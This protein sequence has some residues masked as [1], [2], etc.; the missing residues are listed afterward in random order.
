MLDVW[1]ASALSA[2]ASGAVRLTLS[3]AEERVRHITSEMDRVI[4]FQTASEFACSVP[5]LVRDDA[6]IPVFEQGQPFLMLSKAPG[7]PV[8]QGKRLLELTQNSAGAAIAV[9]AGVS[10]CGKSS[11]IYHAMNE[12]F[13]VFIMNSDRECA[14]LVSD[15]R[16]RTPQGMGCSPARAVLQWMAAQLVLLCVAVEKQFVK[17]P[18]EWLRTNM[19][20]GTPGQAGDV[21]LLLRQVSMTSELATDLVSVLCWRIRNAARAL[22]KP[23]PRRMLFAVDGC[24]TL[25]E[26][27]TTPTYMPPPARSNTATGTAFGAMSYVFAE[28]TSNDIVGVFSGTAVRADM[29]A[30]GV[31][32]A[33][34]S[35]NRNDSVEAVSFF[36]QDDPK[37]YAAAF[38][39]PGV[40]NDV[41]LRDLWWLLQGRGRIVAAVVSLALL[42]KT[43]PDP[44]AAL[45]QA[46]QLWYDWQCSGDIRALDSAVEGERGAAFVNALA[47]NSSAFTFN[48]L[49]SG[50]RK[51]TEGQKALTTLLV[52]QER[53]TVHVDVSGVVEHVAGAVGFVEKVASS[54]PSKKKPTEVVVLRFAEPSMLQ[55]YR[56][57]FPEDA[58]LSYSQALQELVDDNRSRD[59]FRGK[60]LEY[61]FMRRLVQGVN[62]TSLQGFAK[63]LGVPAHVVKRIPRQNINANTVTRGWAATIEFLS[64][65]RTCR[66]QGYVLECEDA[67]GWEFAAWLGKGVL[68]TSGFKFYSKYTRDVMLSNEQTS[69]PGNLYASNASGN[70]QARALAKDAADIGTKQEPVRAIIQLCVELPTR[71]LGTAEVQVTNRTVDLLSPSTPIPV[72]TLRFDRSNIWK[73]FGCKDLPA[74]RTRIPGLVKAMDAIYGKV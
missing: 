7:S 32:G 30:R 36:V 34:K 18:L 13:G 66:A 60:A 72:V 28:H 24:Q 21:Y 69:D 43:Q 55:V 27:E 25:L 16:D 51:F 50:Y 74:L 35:S 8:A 39:C 70:E 71:L 11:A 56:A 29:M 15:I 1:Y 26:G 12:Q 9:L 6:V 63:G 38:F 14:A 67:A 41:R 23:A 61:L 4:R 33:S 19:N 40:V 46:G 62:G 2:C 73:L 42:F 45:L 59:S 64:N 37:A 58:Y 54:A 47:R 20:V 68:M 3:R 17:T 57:L 52:C 22:G 65:P 49:L 44:A 10:G 31:S 5:G 53:G 48:D